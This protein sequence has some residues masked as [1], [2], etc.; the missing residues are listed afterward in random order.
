M[1]NQA[2][3]GGILLLFLGLL[4]YLTGR[5]R[6]NQRASP[7]ERSEVLAGK[8]LIAMGAVLLAC[9]LAWTIYEPVV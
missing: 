3:G 2:A 6:P 1:R 7:A 9:S 8:T 5:S 4:A